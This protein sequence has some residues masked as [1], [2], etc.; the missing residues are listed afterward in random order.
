MDLI[1]KQ[2]YKSVGIITMHKVQNFGSVLQAFALQYIINNFGFK[3]QLID[4]IFPNEAHGKEK[5]SLLQRIK[6]FVGQKFNLTSGCVV[7]NK[8]DRFYKKYFSLSDRYLSIE[9]ILSNPPKYD[10]YI[11]GSDQVWNP[12]FIMKDTTFF[13]DFVSDG[14]KIA[15]APSFGV[16]ALENSY[17]D[18]IRPLLS[19]YYRLSCREKSGSM[20]I[21][22]MIG[23]DVSVVLDPTLLISAD[24]WNQLMNVKKEQNQKFVFLYIQKYSFDPSNKM[25]RLLKRIK[26]KLNIKVYSTCTLPSSCDGLFTYIDDAGPLDFLYYIRNASF[27]ITASFHGTAF[28]VNYGKPFYSII[29]SKD[30][31]DDRQ[32]SFLRLIG[33]EDRALMLDDCIE[34][35]D[36]D[37][38]DINVGYELSSLREKSIE[39]LKEALS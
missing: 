7:L 33:L 14:R 24:Q 38:D 4:Y 39:Y 34:N 18:E 3:V 21:K 23:E 9:E 30:A 19:Q 13:L 1:N 5:I 22:D 35:I 12:N 28:A 15:Y 10:I 16:S 31:S 25:E 32:L 11:T 8:F 29:L 26:E 6:T 36:F 37:F 2:S 27:V 17:I 20:L